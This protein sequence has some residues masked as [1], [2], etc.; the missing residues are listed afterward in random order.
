MMYNMKMSSYKFIDLNV[1]L[2]CIVYLTT[3]KCIIQNA[4]IVC[5]VIYKCIAEQTSE[6][7]YQLVPT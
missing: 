6:G 2:H 1:C 7:S 5:L 4:S 3:Y